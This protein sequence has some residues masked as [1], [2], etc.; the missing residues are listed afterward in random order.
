MPSRI[1]P[2]NVFDS[3]DDLVGRT[4]VGKPQHGLARRVLRTFKRPA[5][6]LNFDQGKTAP[7]GLPPAR[8]PLP[9]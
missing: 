5:E 4:P 3:I 2:L 8:P 9:H 6:S 7:N 1:N